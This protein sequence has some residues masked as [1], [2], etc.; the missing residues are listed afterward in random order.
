MYQTI[1]KNLKKEIDSIASMEELSKVRN[2][3]LGKNGLIKIS[4]NIKNLS[5]PERKKLSFEFHN[6]KEAAEKIIFEK[7][8][9]LN[10]FHSLELLKNDAEELDFNV[11]KIGHL[12]P[13]TQTVRM[14]NNL[15]IEMGYSVMDGPEIETDDYCF[16]RLNVPED[17]PARDM[18]D[19]IYIK[20]PNYLLRT[21]T[22]SVEAR[23]LEKYK[24]PFKVVCPGRV[25]RNEKVNKSNHFVFYHY[26]GFVI[27]PKI[28]LKDLFGTLDY[29]FK[30]MYGPNVVVRYRNKYYPEVEP[31]VGPDMQCFKC[32]GAGCPLCKGVGWIEMGGAGI[33]HP[34]VLRMAGIDP[35]KWMGFAFG[36]GLDRW[37][38]AKYNI[39]DIRT[40][41]GGNIGYNPYEN[42]NTL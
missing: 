27:L 16:K 30:E 36:L 22:S 37:V 41:L 34:N 42:E 17:H 12:H 6:L 20:E 2:K 19:T 40:L 3:Y 24:P 35:N 8:R 26:Q 7:E 18:Q 14:L 33:R 15:F 21:Q 39:V 4:P 31:G 32:N 10:K 23:V 29:I 38:M 9:E 25:Y 1:I 5:I 28:T 11:P 13:I